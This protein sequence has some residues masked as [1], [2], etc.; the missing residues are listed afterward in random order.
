MHVTGFSSFPNEIFFID[1]VSVYLNIEKKSFL[2]VTKL[3]KILGTLSLKST[4]E[5]PKDEEQPKEASAIETKKDEGRQ[6]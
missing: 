5:G 1:T 4:T 3:F 6:N 2:T